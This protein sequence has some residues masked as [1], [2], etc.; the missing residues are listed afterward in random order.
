[1]EATWPRDRS[2]AC[3]RERP[4]IEATHGIEDTPLDGASSQWALHRP[5][6]LVHFRSARWRQQTRT[7]KR[8]ISTTCEWR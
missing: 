7:R 4:H 2:R 6:K 3:V 1:M 8:S 5:A